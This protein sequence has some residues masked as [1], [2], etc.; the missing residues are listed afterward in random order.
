MGGAEQFL[1][2]RYWRSHKDLKGA[3]NSKEK[4]K[5]EREAGDGINLILI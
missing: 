1:D 2:R 4:R 3:K 5:I